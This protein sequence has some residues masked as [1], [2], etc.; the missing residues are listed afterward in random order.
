MV[1]PAKRQL[2]SL[3]PDTHGRFAELSTQSAAA[4]G[5]L[6]ADDLPTALAHSAD[7]FVSKQ[8]DRITEGQREHRYQDSLRQLEL[9]ESGLED[10]DAHQ[11]ARWYLLRGLSFWH[12]GNDE[13]A[14]TDFDSAASL[15]DSDDRIAAALVRAHM[16][17]GQYGSAVE[18]GRA[19]LVRFPESF[20]VWA[21]TT[22]A[23]LLAGERLLSEDEIPGILVTRQQRGS[24]W[25]A[26]LAEWTTKKALCVSLA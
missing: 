19:L 21:V 17:R 4:Q 13:A 20:H 25:P 5:L 8:L 22:N 7:T 16:L 24:C 9:L 12:L 10:F 6:M 1:S 23:R 15:C 14:A 26:H 2:P 11:K 18:I 3:I